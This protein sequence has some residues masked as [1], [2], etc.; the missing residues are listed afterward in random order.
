MVYIWQLPISNLRAF[1]PVNY[2]EVKLSDYVMVYCFDDDNPDLEKIYEKLNDAELIPA[3]YHARSLSVGDL[4]TI[5]GTDNE[6]RG[7]VVDIF[8]FTGVEVKNG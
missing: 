6:I 3:D 7:Y 1:H 5:H 2:D 4:I 8:G